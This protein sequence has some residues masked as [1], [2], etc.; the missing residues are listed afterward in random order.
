MMALEN[1]LD[2]APPPHQRLVGRRFVASRRHGKETMVGI[3]FFFL[4]HMVGRDA[5]RH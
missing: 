1:K 4:S 3:F 5:T 2:I